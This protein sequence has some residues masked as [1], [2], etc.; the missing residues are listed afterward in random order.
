M[1]ATG[2]VA[3]PG[4]GHPDQ[5]RSRSTG[6]PP[7]VATPPGYE[8]ACGPCLNAL[9]PAQGGGPDM[10]L[11]RDPWRGLW[12]QGT[13]TANPKPALMA[14]HFM[15]FCEHFPCCL[16]TLAGHL[17]SPLPCGRRPPGGAG[18]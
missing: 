11:A 4:H 12:G 5:P 2:R 3:W 14:H 6:F 17:S 18:A 8:Q 16:P 13:D 7:H 1:L 10:S 9:E 15:S